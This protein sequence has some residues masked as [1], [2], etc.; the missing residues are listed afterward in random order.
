MGEVTIKIY[1]E[2]RRWP[3]GT[4]Y[5][6]IAGEFK[7]RLKGDAALVLENNSIRE[8]TRELK[9]GAEVSFIDMSRSS[10][11]KAY[12]R[13]AILMMVK[14]IDDVCEHDKTKQV[15]VEFAIGNGYYISPR[16]VKIDREFIDEVSAKMKE[17]ADLDLPIGKSSVPTDEARKLFAENGMMDKNRLFRYR[18]GS[19]VNVY[20]L[21]GY[22]QL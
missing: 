17:L 5:S 15:K 11:H 20:E 3:E 2:E 8:L 18:R 10:G 21:D 1:G 22:S 14:A 16:G 9:E 6:D 7:D 13:T 4:V 12:V 19:T